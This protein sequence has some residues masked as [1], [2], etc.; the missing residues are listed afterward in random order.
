M[1]HIPEDKSREL[2]ASMGNSDVWRTI[3]WSEDGAIIMSILGSR[4]TLFR[5]CNEL[6]LSMLHAENCSS[7]TV[8]MRIISTS[9]VPKDSR[10]NVA[11]SAPGQW[12]LIN[13]IKV[14]KLNPCLSLQQG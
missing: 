6:I 12:L 10:N 7:Y 11:S 13:P 5:I 4:L 9:S 1:I 3:V 14:V 8:K 2:F